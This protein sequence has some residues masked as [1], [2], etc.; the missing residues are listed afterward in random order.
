LEIWL[1]LLFSL[2]FLMVGTYLLVPRHLVFVIFLFM[3]WV[4]FFLVPF[5]RHML[6]ASTYAH[7]LNWPWIILF[8]CF[9]LP[10]VLFYLFFSSRRSAV[11]SDDH[12]VVRPRGT[13]VYSLAS[14]VFA[15]AFVFVVVK[16]GLFYMRIGH[17]S[18]AQMM[19]SMSL[20]E[21]VTLRLFIELLPLLLPANMLLYRIL[22][23]PLLEK[24][25]L[26]VFVLAGWLYI[27]VNSRFDALVVVL[28]Y[29]I[30]LVCVTPRRRNLVQGFLGFG[31]LM[32]FLL[33][34]VSYGRTAFF[35][36]PEGDEVAVES[37]FVQSQ[38]L[39]RMDGMSMIGDIHHGA[40]GQGYMWGSAWDNAIKLNYYFLFD[41]PKYSEIKLGLKTNPKVL[42]SE[43]YRGFEI[44][45]TPSSF[46]DDLYANF[47]IFGLLLGALVFSYVLCRASLVIRLSKLGTVVFFMGVWVVIRALYLD[48]E[49][50]SMIIVS[51]KFLPLVVVFAALYPAKVSR[52]TGA[53][54]LAAGKADPA[55]FGH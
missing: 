27:L 48:N 43:K 38:W 36:N 25:L 7:G 37:I 13:L 1:F 24:V 19:I 9:F 30:L 11:R 10:L 15:A 23:L 12:P 51:L 6:D 47:S 52:E 20:L 5:S 14:C 3:N 55:G 40:D 4:V 31:A 18:L 32:I 33:L 46:L 50:L 34:L 28:V 29:Y 54:K 26:G 35:G 22:R 53:L 44:S 45:D 8:S 41:K 16:N 2:A 42:I 17:S 21:H 49:F 39:D